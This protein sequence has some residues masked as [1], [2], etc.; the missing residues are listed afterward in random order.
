MTDEITGY[1]VISFLRHF[2][3]LVQDVPKGKILLSYYYGDSFIHLLT[4][5]AFAG[6]TALSPLP[7]SQESCTVQSA[8]S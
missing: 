6:P 8:H 3:L 4:V 1:L 7:E 2:W 5:E